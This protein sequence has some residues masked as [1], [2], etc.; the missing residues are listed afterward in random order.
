[1]T[2]W[3]FNPARVPSPLAFWTR[4]QAHE[5]AVHRYDAEAAT[6]RPLCPGRHGFRGRRHRRTAARLPRPF[7][8]PDLLRVPQVRTADGDAA[9]CGCRRSR[10]SPN[11]APF[12]VRRPNSSA[13]PT[14]CTWRCGTGYGAEGDRRR[15]TGRHVADPVRNL[16]AGPTAGAS[17]PASG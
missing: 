16:T 3:T 1:M 8:Q 9:W 12:P 13:Q 11:S 17:R 4:R 7:P 15:G 14:S 5:T 2:C 6:G 10:P